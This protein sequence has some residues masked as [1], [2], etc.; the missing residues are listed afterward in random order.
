MTPTPLS[1]LLE[2]LEEADELE[3]VRRVAASLGWTVEELLARHPPRSLHARGI[4][5]LYVVLRERGVS[6]TRIAY[7]TGRDRTTIIQGIAYRSNE[8]F[9][10]RRRLQN[11]VC[12]GQRERA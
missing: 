1:V 12:N 7:L 3:T 10:A 4:T 2:R 6:W 5:Q 9:R 11:K 8:A